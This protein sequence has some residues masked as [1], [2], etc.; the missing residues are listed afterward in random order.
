[1]SAGRDQYEDVADS[2]D[3]T[4]TVMPFRQYLEAFTTFQLLGDVTDR[5]TLDLACGTGFYTRAMRRRG[6]A[7]ALGVDIS[8]DMVRVARA[9][10]AERPLGVEYIVRDAAALGDLGQFGR[11]IGIY[12]LNYATSRENLGQMASS[13]ASVLKPGA[14]FTSFLL[15]P[16]FSRIPG[17][18]SKYGVN[19][20][21]DGELRDG[22]L[23]FFSLILGDMVTPRLASHYWG[24]ASITSAFEEAGFREVRWIE[25]ELSPQGSEAHGNEYW[26]DYLHVP[27]GIFLDCMNS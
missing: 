3:Q 21:P 1:M 8:E 24:R 2:Y 9:H 27:H 26:Q 23:I 25:P 16:D 17:Y 15:N 7:R 14:R 20:Y 5:T 6:A 10:E 12:L 13:I 11:A 22:D 18:Y 19:L 4:F